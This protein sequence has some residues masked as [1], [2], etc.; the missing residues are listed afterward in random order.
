[1]HVAAARDTAPRMSPPDIESRAHLTAASAFQHARLA[2]DRRSLELSNK[3]LRKR[4]LPSPLHSIAVSSSDDH[5]LRTLA[6]TLDLNDLAVEYVLSRVGDPL[7]LAYAVAALTQTAMHR[8]VDPRTDRI[9]RNLSGAK[10]AGTFFTPPAVAIEMAGHALEDRSDIAVSLEPASGTGMLTAALLIEAAARGATVR[11]AYAWEMSPYLAQITAEVL[12]AVA[13]RSRLDTLIHVE[14]G[15]ALVKF[16]AAKI[17][18]DIVVMNP[19]YGRIK[20][21]RSEATNTETRATDVGAAVLAGQKWAEET[22]LQYSSIAKAVGLRERGLDHQKIFMAA[23][24]N[25]LSTNGR[26][27]CIAPSS[28]T[29]GP[30]S[31]D[32]RDVLIKTQRVKEII[33]FRED[34]KL[35]PT[36]NQPTAVVVADRDEKH[37]S[38]RISR[39]SIDGKD[40]AEYDVS[41]DEILRDT[42][43][44]LR[45]PVMSP[46]V[47]P[48]FAMIMKLPT[49][50]ELPIRNARGELDLSLDAWMVSADETSTRVIRGDHVERYLLRTTSESVK[51]GSLSAEGLRQISRRPKW[52]DAEVPRIVG[53][54]VSY[55]GKSRRLTFTIA[56][57]R[58]VVSNSCNYISVHDKKLRMGLL[59]YLNSA[60]A[61]WAFRLHNSNN[62]VSNSEIGALPWPFTDPDLLDVVAAG[63]EMR[64]ASGANAATTMANRADDI[65]DAVV[66]LAMDLSSPSARALLEGVLEASRVEAVVSLLEL[67]RRDGIPKHLKSAR[68]WLQHELNTLSEL[69]YEMISHIPIGGNWQQIPEKVPSERLRQIRAMSAERGVVRTT[70]YGRL[71][72]D[73]PSYTIATY[74]NRPGN[75]TNIHPYEDRT[76]SHREAAR[77]QSFPDV[78]G[79]LGGDGAVRKQIGNAVPPLLGKAVAEHILNTGIEDGPVVDLFAGAGGLSLGF[80]LAGMNVAVAA[81]NNKPALSTY[82]FNHLTES[83]ADPSS[84]KTLLIGA[85][86]S[87]PRQREGA[88]ASIRQK[89]KGAPP[90]ILMGGPPCQGFSYAGFRDPNDRRSD[91]AVAFLDFVDALR[92]DVVLLEN[93]EGLLTAKGGAVVRDL[94][95]TLNDLGY[96]VE[97]PW[98][99]AAEQFGV[100]QMRRRVF[101]AAKRGE[102]IPEP[103]PLF[104]RCLGRREKAGIERSGQYPVTVA[105]AFHGLPA[106]V[107]P[108]ASFQAKRFAFAEWAS[109]TSDS[110][111]FLDLHRSN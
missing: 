82:A 32:I 43:G 85:D 38:I 14:S 99:L 39:S 49:L 64:L 36:V 93:V 95:Q 98:V 106:I 68:S 12:R 23:A 87:D 37:S 54:Q 11:D 71:R 88:Y 102:S 48:A 42:G 24:V 110:K 30:Q 28:W 1:M 81:D 40:R 20:Y 41:Y 19:P 65:I 72:P 109:G 111:L 57:E 73:Q 3:D 97:K 51:P 86:L 46:D 2:T 108:E 67:F 56:P 52:E 47:R 50:S 90:R 13:D 66:C 33:L 60:P 76:L 31:K 34:A 26:M 92:P 62:H 105:E 15:D 4:I 6:H 21:L 9:T 29:S 100:P 104:E 35:F 94:M 74:Y 22:Q 16:T 53:R 69:D 7:E 91:L 78:Y 101:L 18:P 80:E 61:E 96:P 5:E 45:I 17:Q 77:L 25:S 75:G 107:R 84:E 58:T 63:S 8:F 44:Q 89:L 10:R 103:R 70:Y 27:V 79:F 59:G 55:M 83:I